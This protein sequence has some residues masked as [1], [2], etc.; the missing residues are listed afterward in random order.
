MKIYLSIILLASTLV[1]ANV[2]EAFS[3]NGKLVD[4]TGQ[5]YAD[6][7]YTVAFQFWD[8]PLDGDLLWGRNV[9][10]PMVGGQISVILSEDAGTAID[11][12]RFNRISNVFTV[13]DTYI[14]L[15]I[16]E[17]P[18]GASDQSNVVSF[19]RQRIV[20]TAYAFQAE[21]A[22]NGV[23]TGATISFSGLEAPDGWLLC[24]GQS[25]DSDV[26]PELY[27]VLGEVWG[28]GGDGEGGLFNLPDLRGRVA[29]GAGGGDGLSMRVL[30][31]E[32]GAETHTLTEDEMPS[33][34][35]EITNAYTGQS[36]G[37]KNGGIGVRY[38]S[39]GN[40]STATVGGD[41]PHNNMQPY[42]VLN[43]IIKH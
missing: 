33:H 5:P 12:A 32:G 19:P 15:S 20:S 4:E 27:A 22:A 2:P 24:A 35:H 43:Y 14:S 40:K 21:R 18:E 26:Y 36:S 9:S 25:V 37:G 16:I 42:A 23:P 17:T 8:A 38:V 7:S 31:D 6:G 13:S 3:Y 29:L 11:G 10:I 34:S 30:A 41:K 1:K 28:D 39:A